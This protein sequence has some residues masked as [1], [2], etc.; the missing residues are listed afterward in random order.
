[1]ACLADMVDGALADALP[2][3][4]AIAESIDFTHLSGSSAQF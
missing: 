2:A 4:W 3:V 1:M